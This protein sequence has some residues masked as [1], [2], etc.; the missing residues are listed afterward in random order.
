MIPAWISGEAE[1]RSDPALLRQKSIR[2]DIRKMEMNQLECC[3]T[4]DP[5]CFEDFYYSMYVPHLRKTYG[6]GAFILPLDRLRVRFEAGQLLLIMQRAEV[7]AGLL[8]SF[9]NKCPHIRHVGVRDGNR[10]LVSDGAIA[11]AY[12]YAFRHLREQGFS[13]VRLGRS[14]AFLKDGVLQFKKKR[15]HNVVSVST[16]KFVFQLL[17]NTAATRALLQNNPFIFEQKPKLLSGVVFMAAGTAPT[18]KLLRGTFDT[19]FHSGLSR[20]IVFF[21]L[22][23]LCHKRREQQNGQQTSCLSRDLARRIPQCSDGVWIMPLGANAVCR[24]GGTREGFP[25]W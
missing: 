25:G 1:L 11:A 14:R 22:V 2:S 7:V 24:E 4:N 17:T 10:K 16:H 19:Y 13:R 8:L 9:E 20:L 15:A 18:L 3:F 21:L 5:K 23:L 12:E 6:D